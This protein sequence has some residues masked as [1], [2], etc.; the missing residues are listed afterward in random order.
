M[1]CGWEAEKIKWC[2][3]TSPHD[4]G[5]AH[6]LEYVC[7]YCVCTVRTAQRFKD[8]MNNDHVHGESKN[9]LGSRHKIPSSFNQTHSKRNTPEY[10]RFLSPF[11]SLFL[12]L[13]LSF[14]CVLLIC[15]KYWAVLTEEWHRGICT[16]RIE[17]ICRNRWCLVSG[18]RWTINRIN[19]AKCV[20]FGNFYGGELFC[21]SVQCDDWN[22]SAAERRNSCAHFSWCFILNELPNQ[23]QRIYVFG[24]LGVARASRHCQR[25]C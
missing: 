2:T 7:V 9:V 13:A 10:F 18:R 16:K 22:S 19:Q 24:G 14:F 21:S 3:Q 23:I 6:G 1:K 20:T 12:S 5:S 17:Y 8:I 25:S 4:D 11:F 15:L